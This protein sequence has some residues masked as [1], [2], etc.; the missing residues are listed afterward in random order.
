M[1]NF[2][3]AVFIAIISLSSLGWAM[4][5]GRAKTPKR[6]V[7]TGSISV[8][9]DY[10]GGI[11]PPNEMQKPVRTRGVKLYI[12]RSNVNS[13]QSPI[14]DSVL[15]DSLGNFKVSLRAGN[16]CFVEVQKKYPYEV[17]KNN[18]YVSYDTTCTRKQYAACDFSLNVKSKTDSVK[19]VLYHHCP[20]TTPC[21]TYIGPL[22]PQAQPP[23]NRTGN[24]PGHQE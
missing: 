14:V 21:Q 3:G 22:P 10:C 12:R 16:Y 13:T 7:V 24:Q 20:W 2:F 4:S 15:S 19:I 9:N 23:R 8:Q 1:R 6:Y 11:A 17:P 5:A 18:T